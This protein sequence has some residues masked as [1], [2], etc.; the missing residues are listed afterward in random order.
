MDF[1]SGD[2]TTYRAS[3]LT[4]TASPATGGQ[5]VVVTGRVYHPVH[6]YVDV[7]TPVALVVE[8]GQAFPSS[9]ELVV[10]GANDSKAKLTALST[11]AFHIE[12]D[13]D[14]NGTYEVDLGTFEWG[15]V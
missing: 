5:S 6:G 1:A 10:T 2:G 12:V 3:D 14:G 8:T 7:S 11:T 13:A 15:T 4:L 9:G